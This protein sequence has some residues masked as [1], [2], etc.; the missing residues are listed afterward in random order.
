MPTNAERRANAQLDLQRT[1]EERE[2]NARRRGLL[3]IVGSALGVV[4]LVGGGFLLWRTVG[5]SDE[6][7]EAASPSTEIQGDGTTL[8]AGRAEALPDTVDCTY[9]PSGEPSK[10]VEPPRGDGI[11]T[12]VESVSMS[13]ETDRGPI[14]LT[15]NNSESPCTVNNFVSLAS[16][17]Y[18]DNTTCHRLTNVAGSLQ[19]LQCGDPSDDPSVQGTGGPGY[20]FADEFPRDQYADDDPS[21]DFPVTYPRGTLAMA[22]AGPGTNGSQF[23]L[24]YGD[25]QLPPRYTVF[26]TVDETGLETIDEIAD[27]GTS[28]GSQ[29]GPPAEPVTIT[30]VQLD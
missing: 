24:V 3:T 6:S 28:D 5:D 9:T 26:G 12:T 11:D 23:F 1:I 18:F 2:K 17:G 7:N 4:L 25:S 20:Q 10:P 14:G 22:N 29:D 30:S 13:M 8:P 15:L 19:V 21:L 16:Q 27:Q